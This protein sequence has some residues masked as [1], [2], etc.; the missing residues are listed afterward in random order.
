MLVGRLDDAR[1]A[2][3]RDLEHGLDAMVAELDRVSFLEGGGSLAEKTARLGPLI[4]RLCE[5]NGLG[6]DVR[7][8]ALRAAELCKADLVSRLVGEFSALQGYAGSVY[9]AAAG[10][11][12]DVCAAIDEHHKPDEAGG[13]LPGERRRGRRRRRRQGRHAAGGLR[14]RPRADREPRPLRPAARRGR[15]WRR[16]R[17]TAAG[18][19]TCRSWRASGRSRSCSTGLSPCSWRRA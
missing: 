18:A 17:L 14:G 5:R 11:P 1:F 3:S 10:E 12:D 19:S 6:G 9:A 13:E 8:A 15:R 16:S 2:H 7:A 4:E